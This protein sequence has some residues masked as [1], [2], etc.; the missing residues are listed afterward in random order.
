MARGGP[1]VAG[2]D[3]LRGWAAP[4]RLADG[5]A[6]V[7]FNCPGSV[8]LYTGIAKYYNECPCVQ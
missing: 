3:W 4:A 8:K 5:V 2:P 6:V 1:A 7:L